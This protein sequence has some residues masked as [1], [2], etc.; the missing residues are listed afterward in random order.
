[1]NF[2]SLKFR[3][4]LSRSPLSNIGCPEIEDF[5]VPIAESKG[6]VSQVGQDAFIDWLLSARN[7]SGTFVD[8][9]AHNGITFSNSFFLEKYRGWTGICIEAN[10]R[11]FS[12]LR[13]NRSCISVNCAIGTASGQADFMMVSGYAEMLSGLENL[14]KSRH[15]QRIRREIKKYG[16]EVMNQ[17]V[18]VKPLQ[19]LLDEYGIDEIDYLSID[20]E[21]SE[22]EV[23]RSIDFSRTSI[24]SIGVE[25]N[26]RDFR[27]HRFL[28]NAG[29][30]RI[31]RIS[32]DDFYINFSI[33]KSSLAHD[34]LP[35]V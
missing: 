4:V 14:Y 6:H 2:L 11:V 22:M 5:L 21:G 1:M 18:S 35:G 8:V 28:T 30:T 31:L 29:L 33:L 10:P 3:T 27:M 12:E 26:Y 13:Q 19:E 25:N 17:K 32:S 20:V 7:T 23:L 15:K 9:G 16:G 34:K 24:L